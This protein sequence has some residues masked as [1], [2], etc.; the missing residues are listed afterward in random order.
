MPDK[1]LREIIP[2]TAN[3]CFTIFSRKKAQFDFPLHSHDEIELNFIRNARGAKRIVGDH[4]G[5]IDN[6]E[7]VLVGSNLP[8]VWENHVCKSK[9]INEITIQF[10]KDFLDERF[11]QR[12]QMHLIQK[13]LEMSSK[14]ILFSKETTQ[15]VIPSLNRL[16]QKHGFDSILELLSILHDLSIS[17]NMR[18]L[19]NAYFDKA[20]H[21][22]NSRRIELVMEYI[23]KN[24]R[25][26]ITLSEVARLVNMADG[27]FSRFFKTRTGIS[28]MDCL[29]E[30]R[31]GHASRLL[32]ETTQSVSEIAYSCG[33]NNLSNFNRLFK[34]RK[35]SV[36]KEFREDYNFYENRR[37]I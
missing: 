28:F 12:N 9:S 20:K 14:G 15:S 31:L 6:L 26:K 27:A 32:I 5:V 17:Q 37:Y 18:I 19:S 10:H 34:K 8:H 25:E 24:Y 33:F 16:T 13:M 1:I 30:A 21:R 3:D 36:P 22:Y 2:L 29:L 11:L 35:G 7:L 4:I 23:N